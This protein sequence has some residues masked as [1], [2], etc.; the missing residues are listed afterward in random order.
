MHLRVKF[1][2]PPPATNKVHEGMPDAEDKLPT[3]LTLNCP[4][5]VRYGLARRVPLG[6]QGPGG[7]NLT[8][9]MCCWDKA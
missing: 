9:P 4:I 2:V 8:A 3:E 7:T 5:A 6:D 1:A